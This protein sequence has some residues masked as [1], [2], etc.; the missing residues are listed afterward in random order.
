MIQINGREVNEVHYTYGGLVLTFSAHVDE[1]W[2]V[3]LVHSLSKEDT[4]EIQMGPFS[5][6]AKLS[7]TF[8]NSLINW[9][10]VAATRVG[11]ENPPLKRIE[12]SYYKMPPRCE[13][14][15][16]KAKTTHARWCPCA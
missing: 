2:I 7:T 12:P 5:F 11:P 10:Y 15:A 3:D 16:K 4:V 14:G 13:C 9:F 6:S 8:H 1:G